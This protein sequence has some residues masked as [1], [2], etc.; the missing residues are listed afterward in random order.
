MDISVCFD[1]NRLHVQMVLDV[2]HTALAAIA[3]H[4]VT[5]KRNGRIGCLVAVYPDRP[6]SDPAR[7]FMGLT[8]I[9]G[10]NARA[11]AKVRTVRPL[12][13]LIDVSERNSRD[14]WAEDLLA[15]DSHVVLD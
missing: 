5:A 8:D 6:R 2:L 1:P 7:D 12:D 3:T 11:K 9:L 14:H 13:H 4:F 15:R 10:P